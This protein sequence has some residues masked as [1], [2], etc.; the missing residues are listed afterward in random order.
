MP[1][2]TARDDNCP[3][4]L[5]FAIHYFALFILTGV[6]TPYFQLFLKARGYSPAQVGYLQGLMS[7]TGVLGPMGLGYLADRMGA[8]RGMLIGC[9]VSLAV[10]IWPLCATGSFVAAVLLVAAFGLFSRTLIPLTDA[11]AASEL[12]D[13]AHQ[14]GRVRVWG[15]IGF[16]VTLF[17]IRLAGLVDEKSAS[18]IVSALLLSCIPMA[19]TSMMLPDHHRR[20]LPQAKPQ[21]AAARRAGLDRVFGVFLL[22]AAANQFGMSAHYNFFAIYLHDVLKMDQAAWVFAVGSA[23]E[24]PMI[25]FAGRIIRRV[26]IAGMLAA[27]LAAVSLRLGLYA[28]V[29][30]LAVVLAAQILHAA[31]FGM[32][33]PASIEF[34][35]R[36]V[37]AEGR[38]LAM[39]L[40]MALAIGVPSWAG[41]TLGG[42]IIER[43]G[44]AWLYGSYALAPL[45]GLVIVAVMRSRLSSTMP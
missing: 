10:V 29:P 17:T 39:G 20:R 15:S 16:V 11:L 44:Y 18:S 5:R 38:G 1:F 33:H 41:A 34:I 28:L 36:R 7:L 42:T 21:G 25:F 6:I 30:N 14:Y 12:A 3:A 9:L 2:S 27:S 24:I 40:Y 32:F 19:I 22:V 35:R 37:P 45:A 43:W 13:P 8:R 31:A 4:L 23:C 26:G